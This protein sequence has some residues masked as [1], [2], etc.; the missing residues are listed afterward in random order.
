MDLLNN[1]H[2]PYFLYKEIIQKLI[3]LFIFLILVYQN[4]MILNSPTIGD[5]I[6]NLSHKGSKILD[7]ESFFEQWK[8]ET[9]F[10]LLGGDFAPLHTFLY[11]SYQNFFYFDVETTKIFHLVLLIFAV[12]ISSYLFYIV[13]K[14]KHLSFLYL[15][16]ISS[17]FHYQNWH[18][19]FLIFPLYVI[20]QF[21]FYLSSVIFFYKHLEQS[22]LKHY[23]LSILFVLLTSLMSTVIASTIIL[24][25][26][27]LHLHFKKNFFNKKLLSVLIIPIILVILIIYI[28]FFSQNTDHIIKFLSEISYRNFNYDGR[29]LNQDLSASFT[30]F[31]IQASSALPFIYL[32]KDNFFATKNITDAFTLHYHDIIFLLVYFFTTYFLVRTIKINLTF[33]KKKLIFLL[34]IFLILVATPVSLSSK[35]VQQ[36][37]EKGIGYGY[38]Y[39]FYQ[40][41]GISFILLI[42]IAT[43]LN[44][45]K[46]SINILISL[47]F[48][49]FALSTITYNRTIVKNLFPFKDIEIKAYQHLAKTNFFENLD[50]YSRVFFETSIVSHWNS[51][52]FLATQT[53]K[54]IFS[55]WHDTRL[56]DYSLVLE[57]LILDKLNYYTVSYHLNRVKL[58]KIGKD[59]YKPEKFSEI[60][61]RD[62]ITWGPKKYRSKKID[63]TQ[64]EKIK[65]QSDDIYYLKSTLIDGNIFIILFKVKEFYI[66]KTKIKIISDHTKVYSLK[67]NYIYEI[68]Q[69]VKVSILFHRLKIKIVFK[70]KK[71]KKR[72]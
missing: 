6:F 36:L 52:H 67:E 41:F 45:K 72:K 69:D 65:N 15:I 4:V 21:I 2:K 61:N 68:N 7:Y 9:A 39:N 55:T 40:F 44:K 20:P 23:Y 27:F 24:I 46:T 5:E 12:L 30:S 32:F 29:Q 13:T 22:N 11:L 1:K 54:K 3:L 25:F 16:T 49:I 28:K 26:I 35:Y 42:L 43:F 8:S 51:P 56:N 14:N 33:K 50:E 17:Y 34:G 48:S 57:D 59:N 10:S 70:N 71:N 62:N 47:V 31:F 64:L 38:I 58:K 18:D 19:V 60:L 53:G 66:P 63:A 37:S